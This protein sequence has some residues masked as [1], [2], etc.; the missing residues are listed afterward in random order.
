M[1]SLKIHLVTLLGITGIIGETLSDLLKRNR[2]FD[3]GLLQ[4]PRADDLTPRQVSAFDQAITDA[5]NGLMAMFTTSPN[6][7][8]IS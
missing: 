1:T 8:M 4:S 6:G 5:T 7:R 3:G 2:R